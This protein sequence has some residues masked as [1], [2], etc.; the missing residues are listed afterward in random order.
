M[1]LAAPGEKSRYTDRRTG[2]VLL[3]YAT[4][5]AKR[6]FRPFHRKSAFL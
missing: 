1:V 2:S 3:S 6:V 5:P 4:L